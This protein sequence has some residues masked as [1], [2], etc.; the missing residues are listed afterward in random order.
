MDNLDVLQGY[1]K[2]KNKY[3]IPG[4]LKVVRNKKGK[5]HG[6]SNDS[7]G[8]F[9]K[10]LLRCEKASEIENT[11]VSITPDNLNYFVRYHTPTTTPKERKFKF[12][13]GIQ[14]NNKISRSTHRTIPKFLETI[15]SSNDSL[16]FPRIY[17][18]E[19]VFQ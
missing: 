3:F 7:C 9:N 17:V 19:K 5:K 8:I 2:H 6:L 15:Q 14:T 4:K 18:R 13:I 11:R 1:L 12:A 16:H 10:L